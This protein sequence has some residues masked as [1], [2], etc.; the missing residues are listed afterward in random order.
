MPRATRRPKP[1]A[2]IARTAAA[3]LGGYAI[4]GGSA[5]LL[6]AALPLLTGTSRAD[7]A[8]GATMLA[9]VVYLV[10]IVWAFAER[11]LARLY[12]VQCA[13]AAILFLAAHGLVRLA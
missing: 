10:A 3:I 8:L 4:A 13:G 1:A 9:F 7:S 11:S 6:A 2:I 5:A 12:L